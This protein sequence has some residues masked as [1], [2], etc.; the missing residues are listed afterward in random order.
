M[1]TA[2]PASAAR[3]RAPRPPKE[4][5]AS[6][7]LPTRDTDA[8][9][10]RHRDTT[11]PSPGGSMLKDI[12]IGMGIAAVVLLLFLGTRSLFFGSSE[13]GAALGSLEVDLRDLD[14]A[15][16]LIDGEAVGEAQGTTLV[17]ESLAPGEKLVEVVRDGEVLCSREIQIR[18]GAMAAM[19]CAAA[20]PP[21]LPGA[22][23][24]EGAS[25]DHR[26]RVDGE[27]VEV[28]PASEAIK[29]AG[30]E[31]Q[32]VE[33]LAADGEVIQS[34]EITAAPGELVRR[35]LEG[36]PSP[37]AEEP[38]GVAPTPG[39]RTESTPRAAREPPAPG[40]AVPEPQVAREPDM[41]YL[42]ARTRPWA[43]VHIDGRDTGLMTPIAPRAKIPLR[44]GT[45]RITF[46]VGDQSF[47]REVRIV[48]GETL[49]LDEELPVSR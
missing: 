11:G 1:G 22:L 35:S 17:L 38:T 43:R 14:R 28:N 20:P 41:G 18:A 19:S 15:T 48:A 44:P 46:V 5:T 36:E 12:G 47:T 27:S 37:Q 13:G 7:R 16:V 10:R 49:E 42:V 6:M 3:V 33:V 8:P 26:I 40:P 4:P 21:A 45:R 30:G 39:R 34:F 31:S 9:P 24:L 2:A 32:R 29:L 25:E 23:I